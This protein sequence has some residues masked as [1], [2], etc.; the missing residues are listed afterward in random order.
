VSTLFHAKAYLNYWLDAVDEHSMH[1]PF[2]FDLYNNVINKEAQP[3]LEIENLRSKL[4]KD[5][6]MIEVAD[7]G[8]GSKFF[9]GNNR[10]I[11]EIA[12]VSLSSYPFSALYSRLAGYLQA[13]TIVELGTCF[14]INTLY[15]AK[16]PQ[17]KVYTFEGSDSV[18]D[19]A[20]LSFEFMSARNIQLIRGNLDKTLYSWMSQIPKIDLAFMDANHRYEP[21]LRYFKTLLAKA[22]HKS[23]F[24]LDDIHH[25]AEMEKAWNEIRNHELVYLS[26][27]LFR[28]G[29]LFFDPS[30]VKQH[31][32]MQIKN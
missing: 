28:C 22:H 21:T 5:D 15:L 2:L 26:A 6:R 11:S 3:I 29:L 13:K 7:L 27:D 32:V 25:S 10:K 17:S 9:K 23:I 19:I 1:S 14:G 12:Q 18:A 16:Q 8:A 4:L 20:E 24:V 30:L 31:I